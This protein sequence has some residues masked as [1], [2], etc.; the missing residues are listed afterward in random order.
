[1]ASLIDD[2]HAARARSGRVRE[3]SR[4]LRLGVHRRRREAAA[5]L[6]GA[7]ATCKQV[8]ERRTAGVP[9]AWSALCW[10]LPGHQLDD[11]LTVI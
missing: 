1:M 4:N 7:R 6:A 5:V 2:A 3:D 11:V 9:T 10:E 8:E